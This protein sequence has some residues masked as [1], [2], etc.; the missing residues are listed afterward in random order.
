ME[1]FGRN[2]FSDEEPAF[3]DR[4]RGIRSQF[5]DRAR[6]STLFIERRAR[7]QGVLE[8]SDKVA[9]FVTYSLQSSLALPQKIEAL[10]NHPTD[11]DQLFDCAAHLLHLLVT[12]ED[13]NSA[14]Q[15]EVEAVLHVTVNALKADLVQSEGLSLL[16]DFLA[17]VEAAPVY[18]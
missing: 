9:K 16:F 15:Q 18:F 7:E 11:T 2:D 17:A 1:R 8:D 4:K 12:G 13:L 10:L 3:S 5:L 14:Y 6:E